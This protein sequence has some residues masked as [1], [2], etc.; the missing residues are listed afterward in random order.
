M[1]AYIYMAAI[2]AVVLAV[3]G[4]TAYQ[5]HDAKVAERGAAAFETVETISQNERVKDEIRNRPLSHSY[6]AERLLA[7]TW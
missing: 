2:A 7:G 6:T 1:K 4:Y 5:R 3:V